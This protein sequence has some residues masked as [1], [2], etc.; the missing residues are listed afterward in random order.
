MNEFDNVILNKIVQS[1][2]LCV[3]IRLGLNDKLAYIIYWTD[4]FMYKNI[5]MS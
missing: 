2:S 4:I 5:L 3:Q 1:P